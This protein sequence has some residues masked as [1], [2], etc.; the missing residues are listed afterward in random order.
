MNNAMVKHFDLPRRFFIFFFRLS[1]WCGLFGSDIYKQQLN[2]NTYFICRK[3]YPLSLP[4]FANSRVWRNLRTTGI[5][6]YVCEKCHIK[7]LQSLIFSFVTETSQHF[8]VFFS[9]NLNVNRKNLMYAVSNNKKFD[10]TIL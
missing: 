6:C 4:S 5:G 1:D 7:W 8:W 9:I 3:K 10:E 2:T